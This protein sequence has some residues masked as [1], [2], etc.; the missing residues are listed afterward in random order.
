MGAQGWLVGEPGEPCING[1]LI[2]H[3]FT[4]LLD[5]SPI[6]SLTLSF[7]VCLL[8]PRF[9]NT[10]Y[11]VSLDYER[12]TLLITHLSFLILFTLQICTWR[13]IIKSLFTPT[14]DGY[15]T[16]GD[17]GFRGTVYVDIIRG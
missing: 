13:F 6:I 14:T 16:L 4:L 12:L 11:D 1:C 15:C 10:G 9:M 5:V 2:H 7:Y 17:V 8:S 3:V